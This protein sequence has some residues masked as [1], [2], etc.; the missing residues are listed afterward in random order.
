MYSTFTCTALALLL[1]LTPQAQK[2]AT[3]RIWKV[4]SPHTGNTP[5]SEVP[6]SLARDVASRGWRMSIEAFPPQGFADRF[7]AAVRDG[8]APDLLVFDNFGIMKGITTRL[9][10]WIHAAVTE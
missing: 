8:S 1:V 4:G 3:I 2:G 9:G 5:D 10:T 7:F 6:T